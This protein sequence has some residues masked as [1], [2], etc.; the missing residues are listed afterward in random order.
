MKMTKAHK[1]YIVKTNYDWPQHVTERPEEEVLKT[2]LHPTPFDRFDILG[3]DFYI[4]GGNELEQRIQEH[5]SGPIR[6]C[7][8]LRP[9]LVV[10]H[11]SE[12]RLLEREGWLTYED[13]VSAVRAETLQND[14]MR[15]IPQGFTH[16]DLV[17][18]YVS[19]HGEYEELLSQLEYDFDVQRVSVMRGNP[20]S[21]ARE[22]SI[23]D[24]AKEMTRAEWGLARR[25][26][27]NIPGYSLY[28]AM[29]NIVELRRAGAF[30]KL[31]QLDL[32]PIATLYNCMPAATVGLA[33]NQ[34]LN[35]DNYYGLL[36]L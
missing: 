31:E 10:M 32:T 23:P 6:P 8:E 33:L 19:N 25:I 24:K 17:I 14:F 28:A 16:F 29:R 12:K 27:C 35:H 9:G 21:D 11:L 1:L 5:R 2:D 26:G 22:S 13:L 15:R 7:L 36:V 20:L 4:H 3:E 18:D 30:G 34:A